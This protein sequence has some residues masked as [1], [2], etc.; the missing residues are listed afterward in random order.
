MRG[1]AEWLAS[2]EKS[3]EELYRKAAHNFKD[4]KDF[5]EFLFCRLS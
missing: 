5:S 4:D 1:I 3:A 2:M